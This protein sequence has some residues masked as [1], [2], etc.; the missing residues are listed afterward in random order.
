MTTPVAVAGAAIALKED[1]AEIAL[2]E[3]RAVRDLV[4]EPDYREILD[5]VIV[6]IEADATIAEVHAGE[7]DRLLMLAL[8]TG[9]VRAIYG[10]G[11]EQTALRLYRKLPTGAEV[12]A[13]A[14]AVNDALGALAG[15][16]LE[17]ASIS[18]SGPGAFVLTLAT[19]GAELTV[20]L[21]GQGVR[22][23]S[24]GL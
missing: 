24:V 4:R 10:P 21:D 6:S 22:I 7:V 23:G 11:G 14:R 2:G 9:R 5:E 17:K 1:E 19:D 16:N 13:T 18:A 3:I 15:R 12:A 20:K 8:Q